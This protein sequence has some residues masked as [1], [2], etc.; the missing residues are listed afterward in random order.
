MAKDEKKYIVRTYHNTAIKERK[1]EFEPSITVPDLSFNLKE[2]LENFSRGLLDIN[3]LKAQHRD[4][5][6][7]ATGCY[8][9]SEISAAMKTSIS[10]YEKAVQDKH[11]I[12]AA[13]LAMQQPQKQQQQQQQQPS[14]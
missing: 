6:E 4:E 1:V 11:R 14:E 2:L 9:L 7:L 12:E 13:L 3:V 5:L 8:D 10:N